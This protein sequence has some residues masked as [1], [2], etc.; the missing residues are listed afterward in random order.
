M[1]IRERERDNGNHSQNREGRDA[2]KRMDG[3]VII[4]SEKEK[5]NETCFTIRNEDVLKGRC[6]R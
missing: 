2:E 3:I 4:I 5:L 1:K 6:F